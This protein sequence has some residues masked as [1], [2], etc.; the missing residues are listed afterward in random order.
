MNFPGAF[1]VG[2]QFEVFGLGNSV[3]GAEFADG[4]HGASRPVRQQLW[5]FR[6]LDGLQFAP[7]WYIA[8]ARGDARAVRLNGVLKLF[9]RGQYPMSLSPPPPFATDSVPHCINGKRTAFY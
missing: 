1:S 5:V 3:R 4:V 6:G 7:R 8:E 2:L 9:S